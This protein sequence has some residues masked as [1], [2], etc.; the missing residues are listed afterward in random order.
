M[1]LWEKKAFLN[2]ASLI[3]GLDEAGRGPLA[4]PVVA[5]AVTLNKAPLGKFSFPRYRERL[6][7]SKK[8]SPPQRE[9]AFKEI[10]KRSFFAIGSKD[11]AFIDKEN[12]YR[13]TVFAMKDAVKKLVKQYCLAINK[14]E[15]EIRQSIHVLVDGNMEIGLPYHTVK[16]VKGDAKSLSIAAASIIAK[17]TRDRIMAAYD[18]KFPKY[19]FLKHKGYGTRLHMRAIEKYGPCPI[20]RRSFAPIRQ[21]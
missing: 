18:K 5:G 13:A 4:G 11:H 6:D 1:L 17:V 7:D 16:I 10:T 14:K 19:G 15:K 12:I 20:H 21:A 3:I 8:I 2:G 9:K